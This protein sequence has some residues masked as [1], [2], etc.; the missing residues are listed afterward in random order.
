[1]ELFFRL[2]SINMPLWAVTTSTAMAL[3]AAYIICLIK[4][5]MDL[6]IFIKALIL[7]YLFIILFIT[8]INRVPS[9]EYRINLI[10]LQSIDQINNGYI[11]TLY[12]KIYNVMLF[13]PLGLL[14]GLKTSIKDAHAP[15]KRNILRILWRVIGYGLTTSATVEIIQFITKRGMME[16]DD[17]ICNSFGYTI[18]YLL[19]ILL[20]KLFSHPKI[21]DK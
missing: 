6:V 20:Y 12:E 1:M 9:K 11:E 8:I 3:L 15:T 14:V 18:T 17:I 21:E 13:M 16:T 2:F 4:G 5:R 19:T 10:P 7:E